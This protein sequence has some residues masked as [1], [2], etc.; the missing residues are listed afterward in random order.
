LSSV[1]T[2]QGAAR[3]ILDSAQTLIGWDSSLLGLVQKNGDFRLVLGVQTVSGV[4]SEV[5]SISSSTQS[6][7]QKV[8]TEGAQITELSPATE[9]CSSQPSLEA[10]EK[11]EGL[12]L[13]AP[14]RK[15]GKT[16]GALVVQGSTSKVL[17]RE[18]L[19]LLQVLADHCGGALERLRAEE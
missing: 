8:L 15:D 11:A 18:S 2:P 6:L 7:V 19:A 12:S 14:I 13:G 17:D 1:R 3:I 10:K 9:A 16:I 5:T 4:K